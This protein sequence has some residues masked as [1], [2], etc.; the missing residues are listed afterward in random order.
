MKERGI[1]EELIERVKEIYKETISRVK[2]RE[3][4]GENI[5]LVRG[6][7]QGCPM[8]PIL[9]NI[10]I[11]DLKERLKKRGKGRI[12]VR[13]E[14]IFSLAYADDLVLIAEEESGMRLMMAELEKYLEEKDLVLNAEKS[15]IMK[16]KKGGGK[17]KN[18]TWKWKRKN[19]EV[20][21]EY[22]YL[23]VWLQKNG[24]LERQMQESIRKTG[25]TM[26]EV[27]GIGKRR[28]GRDWKRRLW[29]FDTLVWTVMGY[30][31]ELWGWNS[32]KR[33]EGMQEK[34]LRWLIRADWKTPGYMV[35]EEF[36]REDLRI[37]GLKRA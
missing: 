9:F 13:G 18:Q 23:G 3:K 25:V 15:K 32:W 24:R 1:K 2:V 27:W 7:R 30:G 14:R 35:K 21:K 20:V 37:R 4:K 12:T 10:L 26:R 31:V 22:K 6:V 29:L 11:S 19:I 17:E 5:W 34:F 16:F 33:M 36:K 28:F 8:S